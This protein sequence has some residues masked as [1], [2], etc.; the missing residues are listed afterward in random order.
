MT[1]SDLITWALFL[2]TI[3]S[4]VGI[5]NYASIRNQQL[6]AEASVKQEALKQEHATKRT[7][8][9]WGTL[10]W[11]RKKEKQWVKSLMTC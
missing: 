8:E 6:R 2:I 7:E 4:I 5:I 11:N 3:I 10:P 9:R 1:R